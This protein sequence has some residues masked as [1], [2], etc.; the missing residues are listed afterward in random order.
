MTNS[1][2]SDMWTTLLASAPSAVKRWLTNV[3]PGQQSP[4][5]K[6][7]WLGLAEATASK[8]RSEMDLDWAEIAISIYNQLARKVDSPSRKE[9]LMYSQMNL[10][11]FF[12]S[13][14]GPTANHLVLDPQPIVKWFF[15]NLRISV[16]EAS[17]KA[18]HW[19]EL[20]IESIRELRRIKNRLAPIK[21]LKDARMLPQ[22][23][24]SMLSSWLGIRS[25]LP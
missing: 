15:D 10:R 1:S 18:S 16:E 9:S 5:Q 19:T 17:E 21:L 20:D 3:E 13:R 2:G 4:S 6:F 8:A 11:A 12:I 14:L 24:D 22:D 25:Q 7:D 23:F